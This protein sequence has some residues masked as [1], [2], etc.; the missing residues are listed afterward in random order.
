MVRSD[1]YICVCVVFALFNSR[2]L[3]QL[4]YRPLATGNMDKEVTKRRHKE[5][6]HRSRNRGGLN[7]NRKNWNLETESEKARYREIGEFLWWKQN[8]DE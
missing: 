3:I 7:G 8:E 4:T 5:R 1:N 6:R 2:I